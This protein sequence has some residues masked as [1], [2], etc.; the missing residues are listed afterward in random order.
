ML[1]SIRKVSKNFPV[2]RGIFGNPT[3]YVKALSEVSLEIEA[4]EVV[5]IVGESGCGKSTLARCAIGLYAPTSGEVFWESE[6]LGRLGQE[7]I[8]GKR[9][10]FQM[11][12]QNPFSSLNPRQRVREILL[13]PLEVHGLL[14]SE[15]R[16]PFVIQ[17]LKQVGLSA[18]DLDKYPHEFSG[19]QRQRVGLARAF[20][21]KPR[22]VILDEP[23]SSLDVSIQAS[24]LNLLVK[25]NRESGISYLFIS[26]DLQVVGYLSDRVLVMYLGRV[27]EEGK[28]EEVLKNPRHPYTQILLQASETKAVEIPGEPPS[29]VHL[30][31]GCAFHNRCPY[32][33]SKCQ[34]E[35][36]L[37]EIGTGWKVACWKWD[38]LKNKSG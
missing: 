26:H 35:Q 6:N 18:G 27:V 36:Q 10:H 22:L 11:V 5:G 30:P 1:L 24:I 15:E 29:L 28:T 7:Q 31:K 25:F 14:R 33:E 20:V 16:V 13:E 32:A 3:G 8:R 9:S 17:L 21:T 38:R 4:K 37:E 2:S 23:I 12:F 34:T 19:G